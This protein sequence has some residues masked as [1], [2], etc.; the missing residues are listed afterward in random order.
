MSKMITIEEIQ[1]KQAFLKEHYINF[2]VFCFIKKFTYYLNDFLKEQVSP[3]NIGLNLSYTFFNTVIIPK[4]QEIYDFDINIFILKLENEFNS[5][6]ES[7]N[8]FSSVFLSLDTLQNQFDISV[9]CE[10]KI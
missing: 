6:K 7:N 10:L 5:I 9:F 4:E 8:L 3:D 1:A 2:K